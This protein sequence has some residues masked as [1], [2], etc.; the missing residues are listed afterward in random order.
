MVMLVIGPLP[1]VL[2][3]TQHRPSTPAPIYLYQDTRQLV[4]L[5][6]DAADM[7]ERKGTVAFADFGRKGSRWFNDKYYIFVYSI[8]GDCVFH[9]V[10]PQ[11]VGKNLIKLQDMNGKPVIRMISDIG[12]KPGNRASGWV[13]YLWEEGNQISPIWKSSYVRKVIGPDG[14]IYLIG[15]G[16]Y[17]MKIEKEFIRERVDL[18]A[19]TLRNK[20][21]DAAF[22]D[23]RDPST[24][25]YF[26]DTYIFVLTM[27]GRIL[28]DPSYPTN[29]GR[30][31]YDFR[32]VVGKYVVREMIEKL[33]RSDEGWV[34]YMWPKPDASLPSRKLVYVRKVKVH[35]EDLIVGADF[36]LATPIWMRL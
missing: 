10:E 5:V 6:E 30:S 32:D 22:R 34:Q 25:F 27:D 26:L 33:G 24:P 36:F 11:L 29:T 9:P 7:L 8:A 17:N 20:G 3:A 13:F 31:L 12:R 19:E 23:F 16:L 35:G 28:V 4:A 18:A 14:K 1:L 2:Q 15:S 21:R